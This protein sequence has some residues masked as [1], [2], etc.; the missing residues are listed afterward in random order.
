M[1]RRYRHS[2][3]CVVTHERH[4][5]LLP[6]ALSNQPSL[7]LLHTLPLL[8]SLP[9]LQPQALQGYASPAGPRHVYAPAAQRL[10]PGG[11]SGG[12]VPVGQ[13]PRGDGTYVCV[14]GR[15]AGNTARN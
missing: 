9:H 4:T 11:G 7:P 15:V 3:H 5:A 13:F 6:K 1:R 10:P 8:H 12:E 2:T 14:G